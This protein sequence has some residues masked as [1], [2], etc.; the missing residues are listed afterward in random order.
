MASVALLNSAQKDLSNRELLHKEQLNREQLKDA[1]NL[2][3]T[4]SDQLSQ[5][6]EFL[7][8]K[9]EELSGELAEVSYQRMQELADKERIAERLESLLHM[10]PGG[11]L[12]LD[13]EGR[14]RECNPA[15]SALLLPNEGSNKSGVE[16]DFLLGKLWRNV[17]KTSFS[18]KPDD[19][20][21]ISLVDGR[22]V[23]LQTASLGSE[24]GQIILIT[25]QTETRKLQESLSQ[26]QRL[27]SMGNMVASLA[28]QIRTPLSAA[29]IYGEHLQNEELQPEQREKFANKMMQR[30]HHLEHQIRDMLIFARGEAP[31]NDDMA[32]SQLLHDWQEALEIPLQQNN[33]TCEFQVNKV[34][35][36]IHC[37][38]DALIGAL[39]N[40]V[41]NALEAC[42]QGA[43]LHVR[44]NVNAQFQV[45]IEIEDDGPGFTNA[46]ND[47][48]LQPFFT[49]KSNGTGLGLAVVQA[50]ARAHY[51]EFSIKSAGTK[52]AIASFKLPA[53][54]IE[55]N[56]T[57]TNH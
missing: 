9:V 44:V 53:Q 2:F 30:L 10:L 52:G 57:K 6:Y 25:D 19:G 46:I 17:I 56:Q 12:L 55:K 31:L 14:I 1:F 45:N 16:N 23:S 7:E 15:A 41:N 4:M 54:P 11:I 49:T 39:M 24:P 20:H 29:M 13:G 48:I 27:S 33:A 51:G 37:N 5:S 35:V 34:D 3:S 38:R 28:H 50:I 21:E 43:E 8:S 26:H 42:G 36:H 47:Q 22:R 18:P 40:L 32:L